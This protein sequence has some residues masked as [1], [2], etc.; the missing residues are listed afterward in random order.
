MDKQKIELSQQRL[1]L[2]LSLISTLYKS[3]S[4]LSI[5]QITGIL[6]NTRYSNEFIRMALQNLVSYGIA[7]VE[8]YEKQK[9]LYQISKF[10]KYFFE[11]LLQ[12]NSNIKKFSD[13]IG[14]NL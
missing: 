9:T 5:L 6:N 13:S 8:F 4:K 10:G 3:G 12:E 7:S 11:K 1:I 2:E 14:V